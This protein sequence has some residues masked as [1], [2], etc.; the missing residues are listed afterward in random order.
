MTHAPQLRIP[1]SYLRGG[2]S[3]GVFFVRQDLPVG[4]R[5]AAL[6][7]P[8]RREALDD[9]RHLNGEPGQLVAAGLRRLVVEGETIDA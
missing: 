3:K 1:A 9:G 8:R 5:L 6:E 2:T 7:L 4:R